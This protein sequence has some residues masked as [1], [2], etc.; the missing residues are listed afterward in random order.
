MIWHIMD[1]LEGLET[2]NQELQ[3]VIK[4]Q[5]KVIK[6]LN[7]E[8]AEEKTINEQQD[9]IIKVNMHTNCGFCDQMGQGMQHLV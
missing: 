3:K 8:L 9:K 6:E 2:V 1:W 5:G 4:E 7:L